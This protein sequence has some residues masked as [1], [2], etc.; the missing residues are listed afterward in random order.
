LGA[1][2]GICVLATVAIGFYPQIVGRLGDMAH[3]V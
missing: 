3:L 1:A 2:L